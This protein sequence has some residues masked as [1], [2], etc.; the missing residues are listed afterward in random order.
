MRVILQR[1][2]SAKVSVDGVEKGRCG[3]GFMALVGFSDTDTGIEIAPMIN[4]ILNLRVFEDAQNKMN[5]SLLD[6]KGEILAISQFTLY[7]DCSNGRRPSFTKA[8][9]YD[10]AEP[11]YQLFVASLREQ[12]IKVGMGVFGAHMVIEQVDQGPVTI[13]LDSND[14]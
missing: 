10:K 5:L 3:N 14:L 7:A 1:V 13:V 2:S 9:A 12:G 4:K 11:L 6:I 8:A